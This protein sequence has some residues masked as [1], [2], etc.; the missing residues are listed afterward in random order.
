[1]YGK[2][3]LARNHM[4]TSA[5]ERRIWN[6]AIDPGKRFKEFHKDPRVQRVNKL[7]YRCREV[8]QPVQ[9]QFLL[10]VRPCIKKCTVPGGV[11]LARIIGDKR[12][13]DLF[14]KKLVDPDVRKRFIIA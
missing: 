7:L 8:L 12:A 3:S 10:F 9:G 1:M 13:N 5:R 11:K 4:Q 2:A 14:A 6:E